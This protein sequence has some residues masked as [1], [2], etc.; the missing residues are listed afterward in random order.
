M[1]LRISIKTFGLLTFI[2]FVFTANATN[3]YLSTSGDDANT[4]T[5]PSAPW[6]TLSK[7]NSFKNLKPGDNV[8][9]KRG[10]TFYGSITVSNSGTAGNPITFSAY[11]TGENPVITGFTNITKWTNLGNN[12][13]ESA[14]ALSTLPTCNMVVING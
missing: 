4:G 10:D 2:L 1:L 7:L 11:G 12:I 5:D 9:F 13:W 14:N 6:Q 3:Y 8:W